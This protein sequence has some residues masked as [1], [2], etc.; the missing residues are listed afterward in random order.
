MPPGEE[1]VQGRAPRREPRSGPLVPPVATAACELEEQLE[2]LPSWAHLTPEQYREQIA[3][4]IAGIEAGATE[5]REAMGRPALGPEAIRIQKRHD[6]PAKP[7]KSPA[8]LFHAV[9]KKVRLELYRAC[10]QKCQ[11]SSWTTPIALPFVDV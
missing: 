2:P 7:K 11:P 6:R 3:A 4:L 9:S 8:P 1:A 5:V 10:L